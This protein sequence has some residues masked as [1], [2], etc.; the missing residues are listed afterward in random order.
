MIKSIFSD[1]S[2]VLLTCSH[3]HKQSDFPGGQTVH[4]LVRQRKQQTFPPTL[5]RYR[6]CLALVQHSTALWVVIYKHSY[7]PALSSNL[8]LEVRSENASLQKSHMETKV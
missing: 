6:R 2:N 4:S 7:Q 1:S 8:L 3:T 5:Y